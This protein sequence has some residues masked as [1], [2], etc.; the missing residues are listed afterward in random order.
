MLVSAQEKLRPDYDFKQQ[1]I[2]AIAFQKQTKGPGE[3]HPASSATDH[4]FG[5]KEE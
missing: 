5:T 2:N 4:M 3:W 1:V